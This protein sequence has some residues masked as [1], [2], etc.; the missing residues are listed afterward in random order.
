[1][2]RAESSGVYGRA[3]LCVAF[4]CF[5]SP[6]LAAPLDNPASPGTTVE[7]RKQPMRFTWI[8]CEPHC[9]DWI[10]AVGIVTAETPKAFEDFSAGRDIAGMTVVLDSG[11]GSV[12]DA[13]A[14]GR[15]WRDLGLRTT[16][17]TSVVA[18]TVAGDRAAVLPDAYCESMCAF[19]LLSGKARYVPDGAHV[20]VHQIWMGDRAD[21][22]RAA[23]YSADDLMIVERDIGRLA[24]YTFDMG[25]GGDLLYLALSIPPW[26]KLHELS[27]AEL[28]STNL[29]TTDNV[30]DVLPGGGT[31]DA[32][33][34]GLVTK[35]V[36][37]RFPASVAN[38]A[39]AGTIVSKQTKTAE[40][41]PT[42]GV[43]VAT[44]PAQ[45][46]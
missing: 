23:S 8:A 1:M 13:I 25:G 44:P 46:P 19:M 34:A 9:R 2:R 6:G 22:A 17:G 10:S 28:R 21:D 31:T 24:K 3:L 33:V 27:G 37:D 40:A 39:A 11:G 16:V 42:G 43:A 29:V 7:A 18:K 30:A 15:R 38:T 32:P 35:P 45:N 4:L 20:R 36:Q 12:N 41:V 26:E 5:A 14:L